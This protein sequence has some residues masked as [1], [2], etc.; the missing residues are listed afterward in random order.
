[1][2]LEEDEIEE[3]FPTSNS[4]LESEEDYTMVN[5]T[6]SESNPEFVEYNILEPTL[7]LVNTIKITENGGPGSEFIAGISGIELSH[8]Y[9][10]NLVMEFTTTANTES[11]FNC[12]N[13]NTKI[14]CYFIDL[15]GYILSSNQDETDVKVG[16]FLGLEDPSLMRHLIEDKNYFDER[17]VYD[18]AALCE[19]PVD[20]SSEINAAASSQISFLLSLPM[21]F[22][23]SFLKSS[24]TFL[25][26]LNITVLR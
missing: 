3:S 9:L 8:Q 12:A 18:Y 20:C 2:V 17:P 10:K 24:V 23:I 26:E 4:S 11:E 16:N 6:D 14:W 1:M 7:H 22:A 5:V 25:Y 21:K 13:N 19:N 15:S